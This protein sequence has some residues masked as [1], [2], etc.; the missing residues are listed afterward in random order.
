M[1]LPDVAFLLVAG[2]VAGSDLF[3]QLVPFLVAAGSCVLLAAPRLTYWYAKAGGD[4]AW[5]ATT[6]YEEALW[7]ATVA[8][9]TIDAAS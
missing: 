6:S 9:R 3:R 2:M 8:V 4:R 5:S 1:P 7:T